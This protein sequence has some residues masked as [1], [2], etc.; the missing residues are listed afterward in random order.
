ME[1]ILYCQK[2]GKQIADGS[3]YCPEC[4]ASTA[5]PTM[6]ASGRPMQPSFSSVSSASQPKKKKMG[7]WITLGVIAVIII[8][9]AVGGGKGT[10]SMPA[11]AGATITTTAQPTADSDKVY[12]VSEAASI[13]GCNM[14]VNGVTKSNGTEYDT[15]Q[16]GN[17]YVIVNVTIS[18]SGK[19]NLAY[20]P[21][22]FK[23][24]NSKGQITDTA[25]ASVNQDTALNSGE[26]APGGSVTG[27]VV[28]EQPVND[29]GLILQ[30]QDNV[31]ADGTKLQFK[32]S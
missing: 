9:V 26:L 15:P 2:C 5:Q 16:S 22:Y 25:F 24:Q 23:M 20:N 21:F 3:E 17:E 11:P 30:Y 7:L 31:F 18:N 4:G 6:G 14:V 10:S 32:C 12:T 29:A 19:E 28:F 27:T 1:Y 13:A 8:A